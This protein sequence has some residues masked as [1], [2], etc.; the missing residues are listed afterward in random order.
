MGIKFYC[1]NGHKVNV[2]SFLAGKKGLCPKCGV[3]VDI[4]LQSVVDAPATS[5]S[6]NGTTG[7]VDPE[8][9]EDEIITTS[10][11]AGASSGFA[12]KEQSPFA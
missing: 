5:A 4:P 2:K 6:G 12:L 3:R 10:P 11:V 1:P 9:V 8:D 7:L